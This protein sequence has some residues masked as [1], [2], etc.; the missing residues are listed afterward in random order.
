MASLDFSIKLA[1][2]PSFFGG[3]LRLPSEEGLCFRIEKDRFSLYFP[4]SEVVQHLPFNTI[5]KGV[6]L[7]KTFFHTTTLNVAFPH[8]TLVDRT[9]YIMT[10]ENN[11]DLNQ[12]FTYVIPCFFNSKAQKN[13]QKVGEKDAHFQCVGEHQQFNKMKSRMISFFDYEMVH[14]EWEITREAD[15]L[16]LSSKQKRMDAKTFWM[17]ENKRKAVIRFLGQLD[18]S[19][20]LIAIY[21]QICTLMGTMNQKGGPL[22]QQYVRMKE[23]Y[24]ELGNRH[25]LDTRFGEK[26]GNFG[27]EFDKSSN[28][29][30]DQNCLLS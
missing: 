24:E 1:G 15:V 27:Q 3:E 25:H 19:P 10:F 26:L 7:A 22:L 5:E 21:Q 30:E 20:E 16:F 23:L 14:V 18:S 2:L 17:K 29:K 8:I 13:W 28:S 6:Q 4:Q 12:F 9:V 11:D